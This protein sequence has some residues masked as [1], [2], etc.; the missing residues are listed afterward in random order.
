MF[1]RGITFAS[2]QNLACGLLWLALVILLAGPCQKVHLKRK[3][4][5]HL[6]L[7]DSNR[8]F[9]GEKIEG[10]NMWLTKGSMK[11]LILGYNLLHLY[12]IFV[13][14]LHVTNLHLSA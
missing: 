10:A 11:H 6:V 14:N 12:F 3:K 9:P 1:T 8:K 4:K 5:T 7:S 2:Y 13:L